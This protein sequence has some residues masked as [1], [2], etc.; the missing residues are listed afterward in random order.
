MSTLGTVH[1]GIELIQR[2]WGQGS[3]LQSSSIPKAYPVLKLVEQEEVESTIVGV[4]QRFN[5]WKTI[6]ITLDEKD[7]L[8]VIS[9]VCDIQKAPDKEPHV[10]AAQA[11]WT[12]D[13]NIIHQAKRNSVYYFPIT[14]RTTSSNGKEA[15]IIDLRRRLLIDKEALLQCDPVCFFDGENT[16][17]PRRFR[18]W[19]GRRYHR[20]ALSNE[21]VTAIQQPVVE[22]IRRLKPTDPLQDTLD[23]LREIRFVL[24]NETAPYQVGM[25]FLYDVDSQTP[26][27]TYE[28]AANLGDW[29][30]T[31]LKRKVMSYT[32]NMGS[33]D[34][35]SLRDYENTYEL[36]LHEFS[37]P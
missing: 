35:I 4:P 7:Q 32:W 6:E 28:E 23:N 11:F 21:L 13:R 22:A 29:M 34:E 36:A 18:W 2:G 27:P 25:L 12:S 17:I 19:L 20:Q 15:L 5:Q 3:L 14:E 31:V 37:L 30:D 24:V 16:A 33:T 1:A 8:V 9:Q 10:E 26:P